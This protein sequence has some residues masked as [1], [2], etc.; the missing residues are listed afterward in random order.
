M[1]VRLLSLTSG[2]Y[3]RRV[4]SKSN[5][6]VRESVAL[7]NTLGYF[8]PTNNIFIPLTSEAYTIK[9]FTGVIDSTPKWARLFVTVGH[10]HPCLL[11]MAMLNLLAWRHQD[12]LQALPDNIKLG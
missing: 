12:R 6:V 9:L 7:T 11:F 8:T 3:T 5:T 2:V 4:G 10:F 1:C